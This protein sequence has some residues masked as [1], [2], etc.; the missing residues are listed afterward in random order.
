MKKNVLF[1]VACFLMAA[2]LL[3]SCHDDVDSS[4][5]ENT[6]I[7]TYSLVA[8]GANALQQEPA[9]RALSEDANHKIKSEWGKQD[10][11]LAYVVGGDDLHTANYSYI[12]NRNLGGKSNFDG[13]IA[14][15]AA[16]TTN[17]EIA[18]LYPGKAAQGNNRTIHLLQKPKKE[19][20][21][22]MRQVIKHK[23]VLS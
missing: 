11:I 20:V 12:T 23:I 2:P 5:A 6:T 15:S 9:A 7:H 1:P 14:S 22:I 8:D 16:L 18:F 17:S 21:F 3:T 13:E 4:T 10:D 19:V